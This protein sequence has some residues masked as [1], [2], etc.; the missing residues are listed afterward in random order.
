MIYTSDHRSAHVHVIDADKE[1]VFILN[2]P[3]G[4]VELRENYEFS[5]S[6]V[7]RLAKFLFENMAVACAAWRAIHGSD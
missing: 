3:E 5:L 6:A 4:P 1:A 2:C 7:N